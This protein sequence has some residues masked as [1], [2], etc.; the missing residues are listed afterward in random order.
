[1]SRVQWKK[2]ALWTC[3][4]LLAAVYVATGSA[5]LYGVPQM[6]EG[7]AQIGLGQWFRYFTGGLEIIGAIA[8]LVP[9]ASAFGGLLLLG[10]SA[11]A[12]LVQLFVFH[13]DVVHTIVLGALSAIV[14][15][16]HHDRIV[17][18]LDRLL[19]SPVSRP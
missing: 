6:V 4:V 2:I 1:M 13:G 18:G 10:I 17:V 12:F 3:K 16:A 5:K 11:G 9:T 14:V 8:I 15:W 7:F 19:L